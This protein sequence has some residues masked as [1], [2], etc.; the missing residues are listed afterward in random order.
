M[1]HGHDVLNKAISKLNNKDRNQFRKFVNENVSFNPHIMFISKKEI[2]NK[3]FN[4]LFKW[5]FK[6]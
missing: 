3:W 2:I 1:Y 5:L 6:C 4:D